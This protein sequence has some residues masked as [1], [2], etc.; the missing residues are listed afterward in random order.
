METAVLAAVQD[1]PVFCDRDATIGDLP[2]SPQTA[3]PVAPDLPPLPPATKLEGVSHQWQTWNNCGPATITMT[4][5]YFGRAQGQT[6]AMNFMQDRALEQ[7][8]AEERARAELER[9]HCECVSV[10]ISQIILPEQLLKVVRRA[11]TA[12]DP[13]EDAL[14]PATG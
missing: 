4:A 3:P 5:S 1:T 7:S 13:D 12:P 9:Y 14:K 6:Q 8:K 2:V 11:A 10:L